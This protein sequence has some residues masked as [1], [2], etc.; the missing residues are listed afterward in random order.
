M[1]NSVKPLSERFDM[2]PAS[3]VRPHSVLASWKETHA[4]GRAHCYRCWRRWRW[5]GIER[6]YNIWR[7]ANREAKPTLRRNAIQIWC[8]AG[9]V[10]QP[11]TRCC[12]CCC[13]C[14]GGSR[15]FHSSYACHSTPPTVQHWLLIYNPPLKYR[16]RITNW[17]TQERKTGAGDRKCPLFQT[18]KRQPV[19]THIRSYFLFLISVGYL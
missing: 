14:S 15:L 11:R 6:G 17:V 3:Y 5:L 8:D 16:I 7:Q 9:K 2:N 18:T 13:C 12:C 1:E 4:T 19:Q 10:T